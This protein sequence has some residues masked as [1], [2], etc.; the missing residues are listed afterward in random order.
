[1]LRERL[2]QHCHP[3]KQHAMPCGQEAFGISYLY[4][5]DMNNIEYLVYSRSKTHPVYNVTYL[6][7]CTRRN[8]AITLRNI[9]YCYD[10]TS[11]Q[12]A[13]YQ[14]KWLATIWRRTVVDHWTQQPFPPA[15]GVRKV[16][17]ID[18][19]RR[20][21]T[22]LRHWLTSSLTVTTGEKGER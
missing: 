3:K 21:L 6:T 7:S 5:F 8:V 20:W 19:Q 12:S 2:K 13:Q 18:G 17:L 9:H 22:R 1:M 11:Y 4:S 16:G 15:P 14:N 10:S